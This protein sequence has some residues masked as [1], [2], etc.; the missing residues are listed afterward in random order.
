MKIKLEIVFN[1]P[2]KDEKMSGELSQ[3]IFDAT[4]HFA[5]V[6]HLSE[7]LNWPLGHPIANDHQ[8]WGRILSKATFKAEII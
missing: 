5:T 4:L 6:Q 8:Q 3:N 2:G 1:M 7:V